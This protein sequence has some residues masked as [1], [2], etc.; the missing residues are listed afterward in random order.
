MDD[1]GANKGPGDET[2][3]TGGGRPERPD[4]ANCG[5]QEELWLSAKRSRRRPTFALSANRGRELVG[6]EVGL[7]TVASAE[8][9]AAHLRARRYGGQPPQEGWLAI[10][11]SLIDSGGPTVALRAM[12]GILRLHSRAKDGGPDRDRTG[13]LMNAIHARSQLRYWPI[14]VAAKPR[15]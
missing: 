1:P 5:C 4:S 14:R 15:L 7:P 3:E 6:E 11:S 10:R 13:D 12:V 9:P 2:V 8:P